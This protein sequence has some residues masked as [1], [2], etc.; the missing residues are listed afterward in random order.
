MNSDEYVASSIDINT[1][2]LSGDEIP[3]IPDMHKYVPQISQM[4]H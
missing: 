1:P 2:R 4:L 3:I